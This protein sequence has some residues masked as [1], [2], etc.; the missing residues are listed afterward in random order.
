SY[1]HAGPVCE[2]ADDGPIGHELHQLQLAY[3]QHAWRRK[4]RRRDQS[5]GAA[6]G[7]NNTINGNNNSMLDGAVYFPSGDL[8]F[9]GSSAAATQCAMIVAYTVEFTGSSNIQNDLVRPDGEPCVA[10]TQVQGKKIR[11]IA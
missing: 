8:T 3:R 4:Q 10:A 9:T 11:L 1:R 6:T 5:P 7:N 2:P